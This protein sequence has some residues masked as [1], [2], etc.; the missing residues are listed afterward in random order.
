MSHTDLPA[1]RTWEEHR[2][3]VISDIRRLESQIR[4]V[5]DQGRDLAARLQAEA[6]SISAELGKVHQ[7]FAELQTSLNAMLDFNGKLEDRVKSLEKAHERRLAVNA[8]MGA[9]AGGAI[10]GIAK[11]AELW[12]GSGG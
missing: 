5:D 1:L 8:G 7:T 2:L 6:A 3:K 11:L 4:K 10:L 9:G 12:F